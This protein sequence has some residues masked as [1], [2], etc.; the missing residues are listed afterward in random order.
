MLWSSFGDNGYAMGIAHSTTG[1]IQGPWTQEPGPIWG[2]DGGH[3]MLF[4]TFDGRLFLTLHQ[5][6]DTPNERTILRELVE[7][8]GTIRLG[9]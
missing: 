2:T 7:Q 9:P 5:P 4:R 3:G 8:D 6:N 1:G